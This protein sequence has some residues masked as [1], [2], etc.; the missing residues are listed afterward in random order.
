MG[1]L[2]APQQVRAQTLPWA[3]SLPRPSPA[4]LNSP[5]VLDPTP[6]S[7]GGHGPFLRPPPHSVF[8]TSLLPLQRH[9]QHYTST[10]ASPPA[11]D[12]GWGLSG[13]DLE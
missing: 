13:Q 4:D 2:E 12:P 1:K 8:S 5:A 3:S 6:T 11:G 10:H 7:Q 9:P